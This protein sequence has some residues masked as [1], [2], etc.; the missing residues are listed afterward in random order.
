[1]KVRYIILSI[2]LCS[3]LHAQKIE[4]FSYSQCGGNN[5]NSEPLDYERLLNRISYQNYYE[6]TLEIRFATMSN[7]AGMSNPQS[8]LSSDTLKITYDDFIAKIDTL[9]DGSIVEVHD[10]VMC[11]CYFES[12]YLITELSKRP[13]IILLNGEVMKF[14][15]NKYRPYPISFEILDGDTVNYIDEYGLQQGPWI[16]RDTKGQLLFQGTKK[17]DSIVVGTSYQYHKNGN[18]KAK[19]EWMNFEHSNYYEYDLNGNLVTHKKSPFDN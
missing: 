13:S 6:G 14:N 1:M 15:S 11:D 9:E 19:L 5:N 3:S 10:I 16:F 17:N 12:E 7:C 2:V 8:S 4:H 18:L